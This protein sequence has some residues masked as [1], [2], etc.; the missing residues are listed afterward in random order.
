MLYKIYI[1]IIFWLS[2]IF[3][4]PKISFCQK[5]RLRIPKIFLLDARYNYQYWKPTSIKSANY[6]T[7]GL[8]LAVLDVYFDK[9]TY[10]GKFLHFSPKFHYEWSPVNS[11]SQRSLI[12]I[13][14][15]DQNTISNF[16][17]W[18]RL[19]I[20]LVFSDL[21][22]NKNSK[23][24]FSLG[25]DMQTFIS[26]VK[27]KIDRLYNDQI[28]TPNDKISYMTKFLEIRLGIIR[29]YF[30][31]SKSDG[32][33]M[34]VGLVLINYKKPYSATVSG[35][36]RS[37][38]IY[39]TNFFAF[40]GFLDMSFYEKDYDLIANAIGG[41]GSISFPNGN[42]LELGKGTDI[43]YMQFF[44]AYRKKYV[45]NNFIMFNLGAS[46]KYRYFFQVKNKK[47]GSTSAEINFAETDLNN[48]LIINLD[49]GMNL[50]I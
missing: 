16:E 18:E 33:N 17:S 6:N 11:Y 26:E 31:S 43:G 13:H 36:Q 48:D 27:T 8:N 2:F 9:N 28:L 37:N 41:V 38:N 10:L 35:I 12:K 1:F 40:G 25:I 42:G 20:D 49:L 46:L 21:K 19:L 3:I 32:S 22:K 39:D 15:R 44:L 30:S 23:L 50:R 7:S 29:D 4:G 5:N 14:H 45:L 47:D 34:H 24:E